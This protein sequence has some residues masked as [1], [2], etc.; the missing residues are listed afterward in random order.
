MSRQALEMVLL[1]QDPPAGGPFFSQPIPMEIS[2]GNAAAA[3]PS[4]LGPVP[5][6]SFRDACQTNQNKN[7]SSMKVK[8]MWAC[9]HP[10]VTAKYETVL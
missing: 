10:C 8:L 1:S 7:E 6:D 3:F 4:G 9:S 2:L 5:V